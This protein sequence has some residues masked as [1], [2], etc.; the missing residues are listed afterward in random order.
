MQTEGD[1]L[2]CCGFEALREHFVPPA[3]IEETGEGVGA[4]ESGVPVSFECRVEAALPVD[5]LSSEG[6]EIGRPLRPGGRPFAREDQDQHRRK[7]EPRTT[8]QRRRLRERPAAD[9]VDAASEQEA[10]ADEERAEAA[11][12]KLPAVRAAA[13][14][15]RPVGGG[16][17]DAALLR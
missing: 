9:E 14:A 8:H 5:E 7:R 13:A 17:V 6:R 1:G 3:S 2:G 12:R 10:G 11:A 4:G 16:R 15:S